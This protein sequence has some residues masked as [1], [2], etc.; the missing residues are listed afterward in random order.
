MSP[1]SWGDSILCGLSNTSSDCSS[2]VVN[3]LHLQISSKTEKITWSNDCSDLRLHGWQLL[4]AV[5]SYKNLGF[6][7]PEDWKKGDAP[8]KFFI[9]VDRTKDAKAACRFVC[10]LFPENEQGKLKYFD[11]TMVGKYCEKVLDGLQYGKS[12]ALMHV[13]ALGV[14]WLNGSGHKLGRNCNTS[15]WKEEYPFSE[16]QERSLDCREKMHSRWRIYSWSPC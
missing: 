7:I 6:L 15:I 5:N 12:F 3:I 14:F 10:T 8:P 4:F 9:F 1:Y 16:K 13:H 2:C 11:S